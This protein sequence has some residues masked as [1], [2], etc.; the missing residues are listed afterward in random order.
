MTETLTPEQERAMKR[1]AALIR[2]NNKYFRGLT[3]AKLGT[4]QD[5]GNLLDDMYDSVVS[6]R[7]DEL[8]YQLLFARRLTGKN[9]NGVTR[10]SL[11]NDANSIM[12]SSLGDVT[13]TDVYKLMGI[14]S[15]IQEDYANKLVSELDDDKRE[16]VYQGFLGNLVDK[17][18][19]S[20][21]AGRMKSRKKS[22]EGIFGA[23]EAE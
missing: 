16:A 15:D 7:P 17:H 9:E 20:V 11:V 19:S 2:L 21:L 10:A 8:A 3:A 1:D 13:V 22:L 4:W 6:K 18:A 14:K 23:P 5:Y 12:Q